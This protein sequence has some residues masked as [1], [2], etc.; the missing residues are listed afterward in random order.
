MDIREGS[1]RL[2]K[3]ISWIVAIRVSIA[4]VI[5]FHKMHSNELGVVVVSLIIGIFAGL[6]CNKIGL[7]IVEGFAGE[8]KNN[9]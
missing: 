2:V 5:F 4:G 9:D 3:T 7:W 1:R 6:I 8:K